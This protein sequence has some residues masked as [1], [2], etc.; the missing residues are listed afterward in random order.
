[1]DNARLLL[2]QSVSLHD[3]GSTEEN[4]TKTRI[5]FEFYGGFLALRI[6]RDTPPSSSTEAAVPQ[7]LAENITEAI[8]RHQDFRNTGNITAVG[9]SLQLATIDNTCRYAEVVN[10]FTIEE[11]TNHHPRQKWSRC[12]AAGLHR[13]IELKPWSHTTA[14]G[15]GAPARVLANETMAVQIYCY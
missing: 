13:E 11:T 7:N 5:S 8:I 6:L 10:P 4:M 2:S 9:Q 15:E 14:L 12:F 3:I 1:M